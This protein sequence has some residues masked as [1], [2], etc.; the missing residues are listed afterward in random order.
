MSGA[1]LASKIR[2]ASERCVGGATRCWAASQPVAQRQAALYSGGGGTV[3][4][5]S[6]SMPGS[7][8]SSTVRSTDR[9]ARLSSITRSAPSASNRDR[10]ER[11]R[12]GV[13]GPSPRSRA[14]EIAEETFWVSSKAARSASIS[15]RSNWRCPPAVRRG[16]GKPNRRSQ[17]RS[18]LGLTPI[19][20]AAA[21]VRTALMGELSSFGGFDA[22]CATVAANWGFSCTEGVRASAS[23]RYPKPT[24]RRLAREDDE[25]ARRR[26][27]RADPR[28]EAHAELVDRA[29]HGARALLVAAAGGFDQQRAER[30]RAL[31]LRVGGHEQFGD[32]MVDDVDLAHPE[33]ALGLA[34]QAADRQRAVDDQER[35]VGLGRDTFRRL[36][37]QA[38]VAARAPPRAALEVDGRLG[39]LSAVAAEQR[40]RATEGWGRDGTQLAGGF[41]HELIL[42]A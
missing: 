2:T 19:I 12:I 20:A 26:T 5:S 6:D 1:R 9:T 36:E 33:Q 39:R 21:L 10:A 38:E 24:A 13:A 17:E 7:S 8:T 31:C 14:T 3:P 30:M 22:S 28:A 32:V 40:Q 27:A 4:S 42:R 15:T 25:R 23:T 29:H 37:Q 18:V 41:A 34:R 11:R 35:L 16:V